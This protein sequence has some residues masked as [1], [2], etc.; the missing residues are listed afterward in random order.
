MVY[1]NGQ[2]HRDGLNPENKMGLA[3]SRHSTK[4]ADSKRAIDMG[5]LATRQRLKPFFHPCSMFFFGK[6]ITINCIYVY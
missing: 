1:P 5:D 4:R 3:L 2:F 6:H